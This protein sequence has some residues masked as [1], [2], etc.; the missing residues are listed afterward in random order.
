MLW[1][2]LSLHT[3]LLDLKQSRAFKTRKVAVAHQ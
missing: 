1:G 3:L 2:T